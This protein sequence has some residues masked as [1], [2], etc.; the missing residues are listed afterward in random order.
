ME[1][2]ETVQGDLRGKSP[3]DR[4]GSPVKETGEGE[5]PSVSVYDIEVRAGDGGEIVSEDPIGHIQPTGDSPFFELG[6]NGSKMCFVVVMGD[7]MHPMLSP[8]EM[9]P[10]RRFD[11][12]LDHIPEDGVY[13]FRY[14]NLVRIKRL[15]QMAIDD[16]AYQ[17]RMIPDNQAYEPREMVV[18]EGM[19]FAVLGQVLKW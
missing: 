1:W 11:P 2:L 17:L 19:D 5:L 14:R 18:D 8:E 10:V 16:G 12:H 6:G 7:S 9:V 3:Q 4:G 13:V 15:E